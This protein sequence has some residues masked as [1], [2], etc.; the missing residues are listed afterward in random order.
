MKAPLKPGV[1]A[2]RSVAGS[3]A[4]VVVAFF[5]PMV[6]GCDA[7][8]SAYRA[9]QVNTLF[10][11]YLLAGLALV[12]CGLALFRRARR[13]LLALSSGIAALPFGHLVYKSV[14]VITEGVELEPLV[15]YWL[16][17]F[18]LGFATVFP[19]IARRGLARAESRGNATAGGGR[20]A[21]ELDD[22]GG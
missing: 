13:G 7:E 22:G 14:K 15:G 8:V 16:L 10:W 11:F 2:G 21:I 12:G 19:W 4:V 20:V 1:L 9:T 6:R 17:L 3:G 5:L 18:S